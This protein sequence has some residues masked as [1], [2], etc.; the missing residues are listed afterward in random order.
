MTAYA[1]IPI[2]QAVGAVAAVSGR[3]AAGSKNTLWP[4]Q[5]RMNHPESQHI[6]FVY[7]DNFS[8]SM[9]GVDYALIPIAQAV[10]AVTAVSGRSAAGSENTLWPTQRRMNHYESQHIGFVYDDDFSSSMNGMDYSH[11]VFIL[12]V[13]WHHYRCYSGILLG[14]AW[15]RRR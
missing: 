6:G 14:A 7:D 10:G 15:H 2:A 4:T 8:S 11:H 1:L 13:T 9:N 3:S 12:G 5:R